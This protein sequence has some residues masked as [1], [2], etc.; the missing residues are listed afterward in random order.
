M[1]QSSHIEELFS[2]MIQL[3][4]LMSQNTQETREQ[5]MATMLQFSALHFLSENP[6]VAMSELGEKLKLS[7]SSATQ[8]IERLVKAGLVKREEDREDRRIMRLTIT[9]KGKRQGEILK[10]KIIT[11]MGKIFSKIP[12]ND[13]KELIRIHHNLINTLKLDTQ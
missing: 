8:L 5:K 12:E 13:I 3:G 9:N 1:T 6:E 11:R 4:K 7:K 2:T 10:E